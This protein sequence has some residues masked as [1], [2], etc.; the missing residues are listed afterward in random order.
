MLRRFLGL[1][2]RTPVYSRH[3]LMIWYWRETDGLARAQGMRTR[4]EVR[5]W[6]TSLGMGAFDLEILLRNATKSLGTEAYASRWMFLVLTT[7]L[8]SWSILHLRKGNLVRPTNCASSGLLE[9]RRK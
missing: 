2:A 9:R 7:M 1:E 6:R 5:R 3:L 4:D 8:P